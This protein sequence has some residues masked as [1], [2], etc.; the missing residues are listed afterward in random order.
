MGAPPNYTHERAGSQTVE[1][2]TSGNEKVK[3]SCLFC[4]NAD[5][6]KLPVLCVMPR[7]NIFEN[8]RWP[9]NVVPVYHTKGTINSQILVDHFVKRIWTPFLMQ[10]CI[11]RAVLVLDQASCHTAIIFKDAMS[12]ART[13]L[14]FVPARMTKLLQ[15][16]DVSIFQSL[17]SRFC[18]K[19]RKW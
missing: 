13:S 7:N 19:W 3:V 2:A 4:F 12:R 6:A 8:V 14:F 16:A 5:G 10:K 1:V 11:K 17:K 15:P 9:E 18:E